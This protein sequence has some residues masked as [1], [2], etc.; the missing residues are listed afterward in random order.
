EYCEK[1]QGDNT[2]WWHDHGLKEDERQEIGVDIEE[3][4]PPKVPASRRLNSRSPR[5]V[6]CGKIIDVCSNY[7]DQCLKGLC[8][9][10]FSGLD[11]E[12]ANGHI[13]KVLEIVDL[14]NIHEVTKD[15]IMRRVFPMSLTG[16]A[17]RW[18]R[19]EPFGSIIT[20]ESLKKNFLSKY[21]P[22]AKTA[23]KMEEI[24][25]FQQE[26]DETLYQAWERFN[27]LLMRCPQHYLIDMHEKV[28]ERVYA[29]QVGCESC[30]RPHYTKDCLLKE[31]GKT[32]EEAY[33]TQ[34]RV[35]FPQGGRYRASTP[36]FYQ[37]DNGNPSYQEQRQTME[38]S[39]SKYMV[40]SA[41]RHDENSN[42]I[43]EIRAST[44][45]AIRNQEVSIKALEI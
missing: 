5:L 10:T 21:C 8:N 6:L 15:Q 11:D 29:A 45:A 27:E 32:L 42:L 44:N 26:P 31:E 25:N 30:N 7:E 37:R 24:N 40:E 34:F 33:Y 36:G 28:N 20:W 18:L 43:K 23:K 19:N 3:Y 9:N 35:P 22:P 12:D 41:K 4:D 1:V 14:F 13:E 16:A 17:S 39:L 2:Y 38:E